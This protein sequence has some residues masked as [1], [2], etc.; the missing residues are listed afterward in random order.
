[1][2]VNFS[3]SKGQITYIT[4][5]VLVLAVCV[6]VS[7]M[8]I[9]NSANTEYTIRLLENKGYVVLASSDCELISSNLNII[10]SKLSAIKDKTDN[11]P[12]VFSNDISLEIQERTDN[13]PDNPSNSR[14]IAVIEQEYSSKGRP[15]PWNS[16][17]YLTVT[18]SITPNTFGNRV[19]IV[20]KSTYNFG[21]I[22]NYYQ[23]RDVIIESISSL[24]TYI[25]VL[26]KSTD[27]V[28]FYPVGAI[29]F[30]KSA[31]QVNSLTIRFNGIE[32][33]ADTEDLYAK[34]K[35]ANGL[36]TYVNFS[37]IV[38]RHINTSEHIVETNGE[39]PYN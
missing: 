11:L 17:S 21:D 27:G 37:T 29:R 38:V 9:F 19:K 4:L 23:I 18:A 10:S 34:L 35:C 6:I 14:D 16:N 39:F 28:N 8:P 12:D 7:L 24:D 13:L 15:F 36:G 22:P 20:D 30:K 3:K 31:T 33:N 5:I 32:V 26:D 2:N 1:M 25:L